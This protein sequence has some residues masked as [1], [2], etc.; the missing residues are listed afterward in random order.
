MFELS[1]K[2]ARGT[3]QQLE[4]LPVPDKFQT[5][6]SDAGQFAV[7]VGQMYERFATDLHD[8]TRLC[9]DF[10]HAVGLHRLLDSIEGSAKTGA[11]VTF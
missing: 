8:G 11:R 1:I 6:P 9:P 3:Q 5:I 2:G 10:T 7:N 4:H